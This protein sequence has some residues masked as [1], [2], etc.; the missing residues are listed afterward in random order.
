MAANTQIDVSRINRG[1]GEFNNPSNCWYG[2][3][4][5][6][7]DNCDRPTNNCWQSCTFTRKT[8]HRAGALTTMASDLLSRG[9]VRFVGV[10]GEGAGAEDFG[11]V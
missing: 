11:A 6:Q 7:G 4:A 5:K 8:G 9:L 2:I 3:C 10:R 1:K